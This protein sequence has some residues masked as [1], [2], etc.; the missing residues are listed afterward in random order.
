MHIF[1]NLD[2]APASRP[3][4]CPLFKRATRG[5]GAQFLTRVCKFDERASAAVF[6]SLLGTEAK[7]GF[8]A[9]SQQESPLLFSLLSECTS[10]RLY[11]T[12]SVCPQSITQPVR[13]NASWKPSIDVWTRKNGVRIFKVETD[14]KTDGSSRH[15]TTPRPSVHPPVRPTDR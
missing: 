2:F 8:T 1:A 7:F 9:N 11:G 13:S 14:A 5:A 6:T 15:L 10:A 3:Y 12:P 4:P